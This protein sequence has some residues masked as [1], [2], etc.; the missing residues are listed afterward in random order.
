MSLLDLENC[1]QHFIYSVN[2]HIKQVK[3][4]SINTIIIIM[5]INIIK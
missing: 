1:D 4:K 2:L 3:T 5:I